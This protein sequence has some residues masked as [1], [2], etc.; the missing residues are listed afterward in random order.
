MHSAT[1]VRTVSGPSSPTKRLAAAGLLAA[2]L[3]FAGCGGGGGGSGNTAPDPTP[4][5]AGGGSTTPPPSST[6]SSRISSIDQDNDNDGTR[7]ALETITYDDSNRPTR[8]SY[9]YFG[10]SV[11]DR[12]PGRGTQGEAM[13]VLYD[14]RGRVAT[15]RDLKT[16]GNTYFDYTWGNQ[17]G[18]DEALVTVVSAGLTGRRVF[19]YQGGRRARI[20]TSL[21]GQPLSIETFT[22][23][24]QG[25]QITRT[26]SDGQGGNP[27]A[28][29]YTWANGQ[30][31]SVAGVFDADGP[32]PRW[33]LRW[34]GQR[35]TGMVKTIDGRAGYSVSYT[36][37]ARGRLIRADFDAGSN[38][39]IDAV[40]T[41]NWQD[42]PCQPIT[43]PDFDPLI[44]S[45]TGFGFSKAG[46][47]SSCG[48]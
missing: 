29:T 16:S 25:E 44:N 41:V 32:R 8:F 39:S 21:S 22:Y 11:P 30:L 17:A 45:I 34:S 4:P 1:S 20:D 43:L 47:F 13:V 5:N 40:W 3:A 14:D 37:D 27:A 42:L 28:T 15:V 48:G 19:Q 36:Y 23:N 31:A 24:A 9:V 12:F 38:G 7:D 26:Q 2:A 6:G 10:D 18:P 35:Q 46:E 33:E